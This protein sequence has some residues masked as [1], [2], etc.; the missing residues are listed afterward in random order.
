MNATI[1]A[2]LGDLLDDAGLIVKAQD[3]IPYESGTRWDQGKALAVIRPTTTEQAA[4][5]LSLCVSYGITVIPQSGNTGLVGGS[6][7]DA[8]GQQ[9]VLSTDR[10]KAKF[11]LDLDNRSLEVSA[12]FRLSEINARLE[13]DGLTFPIDLAADPLI[14]GMVAT[15][16]GGA[17]FL[18]YG[19]VRANTLGLTVALAQPTPHILNLGGALHKDNSEIDWKNIF[20]GSCGAFGIITEA[21]IRLHQMPQQQAAALLIPSTRG[22]ALAL[23]RE[24]ETRLGVLVSAFE[25]MSSGAIRA[26]LDHVSRLRNPFRDGIPEYAILI[27]ISRDWAVRE[28]EIEIDVLLQNVAG[29]IL[30][31]RPELLADALFGPIHEIWAL[32]HAISEG[33]RKAGSLVA[34]DLSFRRRDVMRFRELAA[35]FIAE[36]FSEDIEIC[37][38]GHLGDGGVHF[39]L[40]IPADSALALDSDRKQ[41]LKKNLAILA[42]TEFGAS[43]SAEHGIGRA[44]QVLYNRLRSA[45]T[46]ALAHTMKNC[47]CAENI[48]A[49]SFEPVA[50]LD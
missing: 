2:E 35:A 7:P 25:G 21:I 3:R 13:S 4:A 19:G 14:G 22:D 29:E 5:A 28:D 47:L 24:I 43:F 39:N 49:A 37:D 6:T 33:V 20:I 9:I 8:S 26:A 12:G 11:E 31:Q 32:R 46:K 30:E 38:F 17:R 10:L 44:N 41:T 45:D 1:L 48:G 15:N 23:L 16:T 18:R 42:H 34:L 27:E 50:S 36:N 40:V